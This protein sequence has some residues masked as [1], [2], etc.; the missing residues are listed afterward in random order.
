MATMADVAARAGVSTTTVSHV[1]NG[2]RHVSEDARQRVLSAIEETGYTQ[3]TVARS[4]A[5]ASTRTIGLAMS[6]ISNPYFI[7]L[8]HVIEAEIRAAG[9][10]LLLA[11]TRDDPEEE[12]AVI[13][14]LH[15]RRVD[16][17]VLA[18]SGDPEGRALRY[19]AE[20]RLPTVLVD[21]LASEDF[22]QVG[23]EN[24]E[25][26]SQLVEHLAAQGHRRIALVGGQTGLSTT[27]ERLA[28]YRLGLARGG[29]VE[30]PQLVVSGASEEERARAA[31]H[32]L[33]AL[34]EPPTAIVAANNR[35]TI[36]VM[37]ALHDLGVGVPGDVALV[38]FDDFEW[39][40]L[41]HPRLTVVAQPIREIGTEAAR[42]LLA[43]L[44]EPDRA[45][46]TLRLPARFVHRESCGCPA[47]GG[48]R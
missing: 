25:A 1:L 8:V 31:V 23:V 46:A 45:P 33:W 12:L 3:N 2:T 28:G 38:A 35:M 21:R 40:D 26:M 14:S 36:G 6:A 13:R 47:G 29:L 11:D 41:F 44:K 32:E 24:R 34:P 42:L 22:D 7:D 37:Q 19:L 17:Y 48:R 10:L 18:P 43:R 16:G 20:Q 27:D 39:A 5:T 15:S 4:L 30:D 9:Y